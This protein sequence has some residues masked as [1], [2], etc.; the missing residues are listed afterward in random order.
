MRCGGIVWSVDERGVECEEAV[1]ASGEG[2]AERSEPLRD[3]AF[4]GYILRV[5]LLGYYWA[6]SFGP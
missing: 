4:Q 1:V 5:C 3:W 6:K 2:E